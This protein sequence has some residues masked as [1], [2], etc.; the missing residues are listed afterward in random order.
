[1]NDIEEQATRLFYGPGGIKGM[2]SELE[3][4]EKNL[5]DWNNAIASGMLDNNPVLKKRAHNI[6]K[7]L[8]GLIAYHKFVLGIETKEA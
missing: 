8:E 4:Y 7:D 3:R 2:K 1:M 6:V 5:Q